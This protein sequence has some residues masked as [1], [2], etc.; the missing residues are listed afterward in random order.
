ME[1]LNCGCKGHQA[2]PADTAEGRGRGS[3]YASPSMLESGRFRTLVPAQQH[4]QQSAHLQQHGQ[5]QQNLYHASADQ[6][7][8]QQQPNYYHNF[9]AALARQNKSSGLQ[10][11][12]C[13]PVPGPPGGARRLGAPRGAAP[14]LVSAPG[15]VI[16]NPLPPSL[17]LPQQHIVS[18]HQAFV[19]QAEVEE[20][21][22]ERV[23]CSEETGED[24]GSIDID[25]PIYMEIKPP[26]PSTSMIEDD[27][28]KSLDR[29]KDKVE[30]LE[31]VTRNCLAEPPVPATTAGGHSKAGKKKEV[32]YWQITAKEVVKFR[33]C[34]E[35]F[36]NRE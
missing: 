6:Q 33:P 25:E 8:N 29:I 5:Q 14:D 24:G 36:I 12:G 35:T 10:Q 7:L 32:E 15:S 2:N 30:Q 19:R 26:P 21:E 23:K 11:Q 17:N 28:E 18:R 22:E 16:V 13:S 3:G 9:A 31:E 1:S 27:D 20:E 34:T 4:Y